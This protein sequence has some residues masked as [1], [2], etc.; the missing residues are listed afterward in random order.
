MS[1]ATP[2]RC[3]YRAMITACTRLRRRAVARN[4]WFHQ[5]GGFHSL[6]EGLLRAAT[7]QGQA[8]KHGPEGAG[9]QVDSDS[10]SLLEGPQAL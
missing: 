7:C 10:V 2:R 5:T 3:R 9:V 1:P 4:R 6:G 8:A